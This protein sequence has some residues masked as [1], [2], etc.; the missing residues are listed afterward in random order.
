MGIKAR[1]RKLREQIQEATAAQRAAQV[2]AWF[3]T[4]SDEDLWR[5]KERKDFLRESSG[6]PE[7][8]L[9]WEETAEVLGLTVE[10]LEAQI[11]AAGGAT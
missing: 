1:I 10:T 5:L 6:D 3:N 4:V 9:T 8:L 2:D 7:R 11:K